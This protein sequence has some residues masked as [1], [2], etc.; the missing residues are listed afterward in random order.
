WAAAAGRK[1]SSGAHSSGA[2]RCCSGGP[3]C[4]QA[5]ARRMPYSCGAACCTVKQFGEFGCRE[6]LE[7]A[8][9]SIA[10][11]Y[12]VKPEHPRGEPETPR[13]QAAAPKVTH[14]HT[15]AGHSLEFRKQPHDT[16]RRK[17]M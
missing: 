9:S 12:R 6:A 2:S 8:L 7:N 16:F 17:V 10:S 3:G 11:R 4:R 1:A 15:Q 5:P 13:R 14:H